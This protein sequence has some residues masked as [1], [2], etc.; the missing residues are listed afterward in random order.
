[1]GRARHQSAALS[2]ASEEAQ[3]TP[4]SSAPLVPLRCPD[5]LGVTF[6]C[7]GV[8]SRLGAPAVSDRLFKNPGIA[9]HP[10]RETP[11]VS[12]RLNLGDEI[13]ALKRSKEFVVFLP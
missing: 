6:G 11:S 3:L 2:R 4:A 12:F 7:A 1:M 8:R 13:I 10:E 9:R 5:G